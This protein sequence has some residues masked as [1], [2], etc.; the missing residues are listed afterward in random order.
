MD[1][2][3]IELSRLRWTALNSGTIVRLLL[4][5]NEPSGSITI[6]KAWTAEQLEASQELVHIRG[7]VGID[8]SHEPQHA[9]YLSVTEER[10]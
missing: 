10:Y 2:G 5:C 9:Q 4:Q 8:H 3:D 7:V 6:C 1:F